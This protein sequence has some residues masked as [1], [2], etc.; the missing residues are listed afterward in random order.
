MYLCMCAYVC[1]YIHTHFY[2]L[3][4]VLH[5]LSF[6]HG[7]GN[8]L[9]LGVYRWALGDGVRTFLLKFHSSWHDLGQP[10]LR[11]SFKMRTQD[12]GVSRSWVTERRGSQ[13]PQNLLSAA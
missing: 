11:H 13:E 5:F 7:T 8:S 9:K 2:T 12:R 10:P 3:T 6:H 4:S 1:V